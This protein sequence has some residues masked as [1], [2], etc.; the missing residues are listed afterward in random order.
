MHDA[1][2]CH[3]ALKKSM[4]NN[5]KNFLNLTTKCNIKKANIKRQ[6]NVL[7]LWKITQSQ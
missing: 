1:I 6:I 3:L 4:W 7:L 2:V 5:L